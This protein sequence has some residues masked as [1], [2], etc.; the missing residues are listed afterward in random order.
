MGFGFPYHSQPPK[1]QSHYSEGQ[2]NESKTS[3]KCKVQEVLT[4]RS[5]SGV[6]YPSLST[7][8]FSKAACDHWCHFSELC[9]S[10]WWTCNVAATNSVKSTSPS[11][12]LSIWLK[13][14]NKHHHYSSHI[15][16]VVHIMVEFMKLWSLERKSYINTLVETEVDVYCR[17]KGLP[18]EESL[19]HVILSTSKEDLSQGPALS[20]LIT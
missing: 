16:K 5:S 14:A 9:S 1:S 12:L 8:N 13:Q 7:S 11:V 6:I 20:H 19:E 15:M 18:P 17:K 4:I 2:G 10:N 3:T